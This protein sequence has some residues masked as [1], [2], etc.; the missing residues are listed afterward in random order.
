MD[1]TKL[2]EPILEDD[3]P[4]Y[5]NYFYVVDGEVYMSN[6]HDVTVAYL[7][8]RLGAIEVRRCDLYGRGLL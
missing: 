7:K 5:G 8:W 6:W 4:V 3:Y 1:A 2:K